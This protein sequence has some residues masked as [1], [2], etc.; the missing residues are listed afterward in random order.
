MYSLSLPRLWRPLFLSS[1][2]CRYTVLFPCRWSSSLCIDLAMIPARTE[3]ATVCVIM[4]IAR[5]ALCTGAAKLCSCFVQ[6]NTR[7]SVETGCRQGCSKLS[8]DPQY[9]SGFS[10]YVVRKSYLQGAE[11][12]VTQKHLPPGIGPLAGPPCV[13]I[14]PLESPTPRPV[15]Q[16][17]HFYY[18]E[19]LS[20]SVSVIKAF[21][22]C[23]PSLCYRSR[24]YVQQLFQLRTA[25]LPWLYNPPF[26][27]GVQLL[28]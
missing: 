23:L 15:K 19:G 5:L 7:E 3:I 14:F 25:S 6:V 18:Q 9:S 10:S 16:E 13:V 21:R 8:Q 12:R 4:R 28:Q 2:P 24:S 11:V 27:Y 1:A 20:I 17:F 26:N 22:T